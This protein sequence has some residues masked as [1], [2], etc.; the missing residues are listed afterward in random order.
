MSN[1][2]LELKQIISEAVDEMMD[3]KS[4]EELNELFSGLASLG[5]AF[6]SGFKKAATDVATTTAKKVKA[7]AQTMGADADLEKQEAA[8]AQTFKVSKDL[9]QAVMTKIL[10]KRGEFGEFMIRNM[11]GGVGDGAEEAFDNA[12]QVV[13]GGLKTIS[14]IMRMEIQARRSRMSYVKNKPLVDDESFGDKL[15]GAMDKLPMGGR[16]QGGSSLGF[17]SSDRTANAA[18]RNRVNITEGKNKAK[19]TRNVKR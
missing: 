15:T 2:N 14:N 18:S 1:K 17:S 8:M 13:V 4:D 9:S 5:R 6:G 7:A 11:G 10:S 3:G 16:T 19:G 12:I